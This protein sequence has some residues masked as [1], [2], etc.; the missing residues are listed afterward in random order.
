MNGTK[1]LVIGGSGV[2]GQE[3]IRFLVDSGAVVKSIDK[4]PYP[5]DGVEDVQ[6]AQVNLAM[7]NLDPI[8]EFQPEVVFHLAA[9]F[10]R[11]DESVSFWTENWQDN[12]LASHRLIDILRGSD[13]LETVV[14]ASSYLVYDSDVY[15]S[16][17]EP[18]T[19]MLLNEQAAIDPRNLCG[20]AKY[21][22]ERELSFF[23]E[24]EKDVRVVS[25]RIF[26][27]YGRGS[28]DVISRWVRAALRDEPISAYNVKN[29]FDFIHARDVADGLFRLASTD[30]A[31]GP[32]NLGRGTPKRIS[33]VIS[34]LNDEIPG[35]AE[36]ITSGG[37][38]DLYETSCADVSQLVD[39]T[40]WRP[41][42]DLESGI[43]DIV[44][45]E[46]SRLEE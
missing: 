29:M 41:T 20:A 3:L 42:I 9:A 30:A 27:V 18:D 7:D 1:V 33:D 23:A 14:F 2:I 19:P 22:T 44:D 5:D 35:T 26:R 10:E 6:S 21:Y 45:Y 4:R 46:R 37:L 34:I 40:D 36:H 32:V 8:V 24:T 25:P 12:T 16:P 17:V 31:S 28:K 43:R 13:T 38:K 11:T 39:L 15:L